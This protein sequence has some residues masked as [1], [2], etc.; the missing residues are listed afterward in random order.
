M[1]LGIVLLAGMGLGAITNAGIDAANV[2]KNCDTA[3]A[4]LQSLQDMR[5]FYN[6]I[7]PVYTGDNKNLQTIL[8]SLKQ[9]H[10]KNQTKIEY[11]LKHHNDITKRMELILL[12][13]LCVIYALFL[14]KSGLPQ[15]S[16]KYI[17]NK[18]K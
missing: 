12:I 9:E 17:S 11:Y 18:L 14:Y 8:D 6:S 5:K 2:G 3:K 15:Y 4:T 7:A 1:S 10:S 13:P 16:Y